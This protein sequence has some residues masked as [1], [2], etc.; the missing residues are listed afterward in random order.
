MQRWFVSSITLPQRKEKRSSGM[1][2][3][4]SLLKTLSSIGTS[5]T[6][7]GIGSTIPTI[8]GAAEMQVDGGFESSSYNM[9]PDKIIPGNLSSRRRDPVIIGE[10][11]NVWKPPP[12]FTKLGKSRLLVSELAPLSASLNPFAS[13]N[14]LYYGKHCFI[15]NVIFQYSH[16]IT[17]H[18]ITSHHIYILISRL[19]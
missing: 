11:G 5:A 19:Y 16:H 2:T 6:A 9:L 8:S 7:M 15:Y 17:S 1:M 10:E 14:E 3:R 12:I 18:H 13:D 4:S